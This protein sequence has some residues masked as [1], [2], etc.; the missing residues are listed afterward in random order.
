MLQAHRV[1]TM[2][3]TIAQSLQIRGLKQGVEAPQLVGLQA[4]P[5]LTSAFSLSCSEKV[6]GCQMALSGKWGIAGHCAKPGFERPPASRKN[7]TALAA[8]SRLL[9]DTTYFEQPSLTYRIGPFKLTTPLTALRHHPLRECSFG[10][11]NHCAS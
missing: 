2:Y 4:L 6:L 11:Q 8:Y 10:H 9:S 5:G 1:R 7:R 3:K